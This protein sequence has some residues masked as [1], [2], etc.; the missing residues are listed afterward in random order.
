LDFDPG[1]RNV[2]LVR[3]ILVVAAVLAALGLIV[4]FAVP[5]TGR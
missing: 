5:G 2:H 4:G 1:R 3:V